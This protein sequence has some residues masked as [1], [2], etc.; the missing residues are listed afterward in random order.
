[1][2]CGLAAV[3]RRPVAGFERSG[4]PGG[5]P[6][7]REQGLRGVLAVVWRDLGAMLVLVGEIWR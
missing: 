6:E 5:D 4:D 1:M 7:L 3:G 2:I